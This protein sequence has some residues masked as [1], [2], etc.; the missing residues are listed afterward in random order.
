[1]PR[2]LSS[3]KMEVVRNLLAEDPVRACVRAR[4]H[5]LKAAPTFALTLAI[6]LTPRPCCTPC[7]NALS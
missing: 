7:S 3:Q 2:W 6:L 5:T 4:T 1:M